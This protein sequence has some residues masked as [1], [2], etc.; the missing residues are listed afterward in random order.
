MG[1]KRNNPLD[2][3][4]WGDINKKYIDALGEYSAFNPFMSE[5]KPDVDS[6]LTDSMDNWWQ[7]LKSGM[8]NKNKEVL[9]NMLTQSKNFYL[10]GEQFSKIMEGMNKFKLKNK[11]F[12]SFLNDKF[13]EIESFLKDNQNNFM[14]N[15]YFDPYKQSPE[16]FKKIFSNMNLYDFQE[17]GFKNIV[18]Q[19]LSSP[20]FGSNR[21]TQEKIQESIKLWIVYQNNFFEYQKNIAKLNKKSLD[22]LQIEILS[23][24]KREEN[25]SSMKQMYDLWVEISE[26][27]YGKYVLTNKYADLNSRL[28]NSLMAYKKKNNEIKEEVMS[29]LN[30]PTNKSLS[31]IERRQ[32]ELRKKN[33]ELSIQLKGLKEELEKLSN[34]DNSKD[35]SANET[36]KKKVLIGKKVSKKVGKKISKKKPS[37]SAVKP[38]VKKKASISKVGLL[39]KKINKS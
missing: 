19:S 12:S 36:Q 39:N 16:A 37:T 1:Q 35:S 17:N 24:H 3:L 23:M 34:K 13:E 11:K 18:N 21:E 27:V 5:P 25:I 29:S 2:S 9:D 28:I 31:I 10:L 4:D 8:P 22:L 38:N 20:C 30:L 15:M 32:Y 33:K 7:L 6:L 26:K 14:E